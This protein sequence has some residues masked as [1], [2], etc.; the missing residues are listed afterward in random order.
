PTCF[1]RF[2]VVL[3]TGISCVF[4]TT[5]MLCLWPHHPFSVRVV[6]PFGLLN[7]C[8]GSSFQLRSSLHFSPLF[9]LSRYGIGFVTVDV[10]VF[11]TVAV[12]V[13]GCCSI[14]AVVFR[15]FL[16]VVS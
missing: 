6:K 1:R 5:V 14:P 16:V 8:G 12:L 4:R 2:L 15:E 3:G 13:L 10:W 9:S 11:A 7:R